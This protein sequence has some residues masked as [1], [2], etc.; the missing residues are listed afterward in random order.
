MDELGG[1]ACGFLLAMSVW[2]CDPADVCPPP[3]YFISLE[4]IS[5]SN[6]TSWAS[7]A[8]GGQDCDLRVP[9]WDEW[10]WRGRVGVG[11]V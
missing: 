6:L 7:L 2:D 1:M 4:G 11:D 10:G 9:G 3:L 5:S 8:L